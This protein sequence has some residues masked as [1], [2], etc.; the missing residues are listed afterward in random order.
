MSLTIHEELLQGSDEWLAQRLGIVTA[1]VVGNLIASRR[2]GASDYTCPACGAESDKPCIS[3]VKAGAVLKTM[4][5]ERGQYAREQNGVVLEPSDS[6]NAR[7]LTMLLASERINGWSDP[8]WVSDDMM[9]GIEDE[10]RAREVYARNFAP[11]T[12]VGFMTED[13]WG[14]TLGYS[15][16]GLVGDDGLIEIKSRRPKKQVE[17]VISGRPPAINMPQLQ[18][19]LLVSGRKWIDYVSYAGGMHLFVTRVY[20]DEQWFDAIVK[21]V[22]VFEDNAAD[23]VAQYSNST[24]GMPLTERALDMEITF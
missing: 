8:T 16:D 6:D 19:G 7:S 21:A 2:L 17:T 3:K 11:V 24:V 4:H 1:S 22:R 9:R 12:E 15:P 14:F 18:A 13:R 10:P 20:P 23:I 5:P